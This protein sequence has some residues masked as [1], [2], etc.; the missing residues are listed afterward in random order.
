MN[1]KEA[2]KIKYVLV[3]DDLR[4]EKDSKKFTILGLYAG[5]II[6][7]SLPALLPKLA[8]RIC[9]HPVKVDDKMSIELI[10]PD[11][12]LIGSGQFRI[13]SIEDPR[14]EAVVNLILSPF[15]VEKSGEYKLVLKRGGGN[16][17]SIVAFEA[18][19]GKPTK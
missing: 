4:E 17:F 16:K 7:G 14:G 9:L 15:P 5:K 3:C 11:G 13:D 1:R 8:F 12:E 19:L 2:T 10:R 6:L 18:V